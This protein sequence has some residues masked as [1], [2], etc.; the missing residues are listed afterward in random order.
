MSDSSYEYLKM[1][2]NESH[3]LTMTHSCYCDL[4]DTKCV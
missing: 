1:N 4:H 2:Q 3:C